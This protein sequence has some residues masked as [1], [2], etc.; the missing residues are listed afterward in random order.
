MR[1]EISAVLIAAFALA[2]CMGPEGNPNG[3]SYAT[4]TSGMIATAPQAV[5][6]DNYDPYGKPSDFADMDIGSAAIAPS[7]TPPMNLTT[8]GASPMPAHPGP[9]PQ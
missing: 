3:Q 9:L 8:Q 5:G 4:D 2:G 1:F 6:K 7:A